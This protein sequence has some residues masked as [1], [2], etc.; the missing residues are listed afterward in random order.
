[1]AL[2]I[3]PAGRIAGV[4]ASSAGFPDSKPRKTV[5]FP[6]F[7][8]AGTE[9]FN[10][11]EM[12]RLDR[13][14]VSPHRLAV[15]EGGHLWLSSDLAIE[16]VEWM[17]I[18]AA[19][20]GLPVD[21]D[22]LD[23]IYEKRVSALDALASDKDR[24]LALTALAAD[25]DTLKDVSGFTARAALLARDKHVRDAFKKERDDETQEQREIQEIVDAERR[26]PDNRPAALGELRAAWKKLS[27][28]SNAPA[29]SPD[30]RRARR[31]L[32]GL[33]MGAAERVSDPDYRKIVDEFRPSRDPLRL[34][35]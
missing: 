29:D 24:Y 30:R 22:R 2:G 10:L 11:L 9:D 5:P 6:V 4:I 35:R 20:S 7:G 23:R 12:R 25:F 16:A 34:V 31:V 26:L 27:V 15:F 8:T 14:L 21:R 32:R 28:A 33:A 19:R 3:A 17:E 18:Q 13:A 1:V